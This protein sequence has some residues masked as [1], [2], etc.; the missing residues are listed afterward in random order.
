MSFTSWFR[1]TSDGPRVA[2]E[3]PF[4]QYGYCRYHG[5]SRWY[6]RSRFAWMEAGTARSVFWNGLP[7]IAF[8]SPNVNRMTTRMMGIVQITRLITSLVM[9]AASGARFGTGGGR[10]ARPR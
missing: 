7:L 9:R 1:R 8:I 3:T 5:W 10:W 4:P 6:L 2:V